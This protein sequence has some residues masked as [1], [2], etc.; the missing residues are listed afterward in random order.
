[1]IGNI[2]SAQSMLCSFAFAEKYAMYAAIREKYAVL[3]AE[4]KAMRDKCF[5]S[6]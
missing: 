1:M 2:E 5:L 4:Y 6:V 3:E